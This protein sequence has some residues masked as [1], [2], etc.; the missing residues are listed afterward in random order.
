MARALSGGSMPTTMG[1][2][3][4]AA[5]NS[6]PN[7]FSSRNCRTLI[8]PFAGCGSLQA[9]HPWPVDADRVA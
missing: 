5:N 4:R 3:M 2:E 8:G 7:S 1:Y 9:P 6:R